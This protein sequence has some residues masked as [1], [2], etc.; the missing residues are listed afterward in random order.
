MFQ[1]HQTEVL[2][3]G[4]GPVGLFTAL[5]LTERG[6]QVQVIEEQWRTA[7]RSYA[8]ALHPATLRLLA[9][10][11]L[12]EE[13]VRLGYRVDRLVFH[14]HR[15][16]CGELQFSGLGGSFP[17]VL[18]LPQEA[19]EDLLRERLEKRARI[20]WNHR[21]AEIKTSEEQV[22]SRIE[23]LGKDSSGY[24]VARTEW[25]VEKVIDSRAPFVVGADGHRS[26]VRKS[27]GIEFESVGKP[28]SFA[29]FEFES[30][31]D[32]AH[33]MRIV[34]E[35]K[36]TSVLWP[37]GN[38][39]FRWS[40]ELDK[41]DEIVDPRVK[42]RVFV[43][44]RNESYPRATREDLVELIAERA[45]WFEGEIRELAWSAVIRFEKRLAQ[46]YG[47]HRAWLL[48]DAVHLAFPVGIQSMNVGFREAHRLVQG[49]YGVLRSRVAPDS[50]RSYEEESLAEWRILMGIAGKSTLAGAADPWVETYADRI[51]S[52]IP[53][54][55]E[56]LRVLLER[57]GLELH[58]DD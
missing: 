17:F 39:R 50:L 49:L 57:I 41:E 11:G 43:Q 15:E 12:A 32:P 19:L 7:S 47:S 31:V 38:R 25:V 48:G 34:L 53:A 54:S 40:F 18:V 10:L 56:D 24:A 45:P 21:L 3:V 9:E 4:A 35:K 33:E 37:L 16:I 42:S 28:H 36:R 51:P 26:T 14:D 52:C 20:L 44:L 23:E 58:Q 29:V 13:V 27:L 5:L 8:L 22:E 6:I 2:V 1:K 30:D 46:K 55:G